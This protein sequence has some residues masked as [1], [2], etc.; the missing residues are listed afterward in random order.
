[1][2]HLQYQDQSFESSSKKPRE[3]YAYLKVPY[4]ILNSPRLVQMA[5]RAKISDRAT[6]GL[7][8]LSRLLMMEM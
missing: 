2:Y 7:L 4:D 3:E 6:V 8:G 1:M 5:D